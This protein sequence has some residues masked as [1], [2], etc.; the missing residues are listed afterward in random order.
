MATS[1]TP[2][3]PTTPSPGAP[4]SPGYPG[5]WKSNWDNHK[6]RLPMLMVALLA[7]GAGWFM[8]QD[9][10]DKS[11][12]LATSVAEVQSLKKENSDLVGKLAT[13]SSQKLECVGATADEVKRAVAGVCVGKTTYVPVRSRS[14][15][16]PLVERP[17]PVAPPAPSV[18]RAPGGVTC[19]VLDKN[20]K[21]LADFLDARNNPKGIVVASGAE[22]LRERDAFVASNNL[23]TVTREVIERK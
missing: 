16:V 2:A 11:A 22:C 13:A 4:G 23:H 20:G 7:F 12:Q 3:I 5:F 17:S 15:P 14:T 21:V 18:A 1:A 19:S 8:S 6:H 9:K 10:Y